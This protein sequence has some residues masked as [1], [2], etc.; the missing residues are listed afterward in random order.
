MRNTALLA[1][2]AAIA[3][4]A[5]ALAEKWDMPL[6]YPATNYHSETAASFGA[7][8]AEAT[9]NAIEIVTHPNGS[10]FSGNDIKRAVVGIGSD[11][12]A[13][14][15][16]RRAPARA[17]TSGQLTARNDKAHREVI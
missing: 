9:D 6:A 12:D 17:V 10:L 11:V 4:S 2:T 3:F 5:P 1:A 14:V 13:S 15:D 7:C 8:V 16:V